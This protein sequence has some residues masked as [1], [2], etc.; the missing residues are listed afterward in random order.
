MAFSLLALPLL[1]QAIAIIQKYQAAAIAAINPSL[2]SNAQLAAIQ[3]FHTGPKMRTAFP[4][5]TL[6][7]EGTAF[8]EPSQ[9]TR[10]EHL[11]LVITLEAGNFD[12][13]IAQSQAIGYL[14]MLDYIF[15][16]LTG[17][18]T[19]FTDWESSLPIVHEIAPSG[20]TKPW[21]TGTVKQIFI[22]TEEQSLVLRDEQETPVIQVSLRMRF[23]LEE[24]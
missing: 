22:E 3:E 5:V 15:S 23:D 4:W 11:Q 19:N 14:A 17:G 18:G 10:E 12:S 21:V 6:A 24:N 13:E 1:P 2:P 7:Y 9:E 16:G 20:T 8:S